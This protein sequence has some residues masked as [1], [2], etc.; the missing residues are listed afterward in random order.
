MSL[1]DATI[2]LNLPEGHTE[3]LVEG[4]SVMIN[5]NAFKQ[6]EG[7]HVQ[8]G[9][10]KVDDLPL[11]KSNTTHSLQFT[12]PDYIGANTI[13][14]HSK[15]GNSISNKLEVVIA[16]KMLDYEQFKF[17]RDEHIPDLVKGSGAEEPDEMYP[18]A[19]SSIEE[20]K[21]MLNIEQLLDFS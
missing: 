15:D 1:P 17:L 18:G 9:A 6:L 13:C 10:A 8:L 2:E 19:T 21:I 5:V 12:V 4:E 20:E 7:V 16:P 11:V 14:L 3:N